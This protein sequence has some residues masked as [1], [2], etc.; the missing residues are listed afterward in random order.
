M[1]YAPRF[2][3]QVYSM[4]TVTVSLYEYGLPR[5]IFIVEERESYFS[6]CFPMVTDLKFI[7]S[8]SNSTAVMFERYG[9]NVVVVFPITIFFVSSNESSIL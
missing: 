6:D 2:G 4:E 7:S 1:K 9:T 8:A 3:M 5:Y